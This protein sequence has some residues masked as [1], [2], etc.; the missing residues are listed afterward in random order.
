MDLSR[1]ETISFAPERRMLIHTYSDAGQL[2]PLAV[3]CYSL[4]EML[5]EKIRDL[6][7]QRR[8]AV[9]RDLWCKG[10]YKDHYPKH[11][12]PP[13]PPTLPR[14]RSSASF[15]DCVQPARMVA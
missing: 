9:S 13:R 10:L 3:T 14:P 15:A 11:H 12:M 1:G 4:P 2:P 7:G 8:F 6:S 5:A